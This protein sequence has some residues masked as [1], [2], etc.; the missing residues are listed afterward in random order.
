M[1]I[2]LIHY[3]G[4]FPSCDLVIVGHHDL[5]ASEAKVIELKNFF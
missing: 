4:H 1:S 2:F 3:H 5:S